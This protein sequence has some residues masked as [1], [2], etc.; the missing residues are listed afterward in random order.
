MTGQCGE[1]YRSGEAENRNDVM[2]Y[3]TTFIQF[4]SLKHFMTLF[5]LSIAVKTLVNVVD[6]FSRYYLN[7]KCTHL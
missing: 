2:K 4:Q 5:L 6:L 1:G 7:I 3:Q